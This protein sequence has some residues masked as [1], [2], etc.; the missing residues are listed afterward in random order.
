MFICGSR[1]EWTLPKVP[2]YQHRPEG[3]GVGDTDI[4]S[5]MLLRRPRDHGVSL[6]GVFNKGKFIVLTKAS[7]NPDEGV[8][9]PPGESRKVS[10]CGRKAAPPWPYPSRCP[11]PTSRVWVGEGMILIRSNDEQWNKFWSNPAHRAH[12]DRLFWVWLQVPL[13]P[14]RA[15][16]G[17]R[18]LY[19]GSSQFGKPTAR[20]GVHREPL[21]AG[22]VGMFRVATRIDW[23]S[24]GNLPFG[25]VCS[26]RTPA[27]SFAT[28]HG[29]GAGHRRELREKAPWTEESRG[30]SPRGDGHPSG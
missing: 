3:V 2:A 23:P 12:N 8:P 25:A 6:S 4:A 11:A 18:K 5:F 13:E 14:E 19:R 20:G 10:V 21:D 16:P 29:G 26:R 28:R 30:M 27:R 15:S 24:K 22:Y 7:R 9:Y 17:H 1:H